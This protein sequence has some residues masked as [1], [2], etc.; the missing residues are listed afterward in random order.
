MGLVIVL[1]TVSLSAGPNTR[2]VTLTF[3]DSLTLPDSA[4]VTVD[5]GDG[6]QSSMVCVKEG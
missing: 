4:T 6:T 5:Y 3:P 2:S 1:Y